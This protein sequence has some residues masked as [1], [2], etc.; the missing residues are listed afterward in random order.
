MVVKKTAMGKRLRFFFAIFSTS[1]GTMED[2]GDLYQITSFVV[3]LNVQISCGSF[4]KLLF[5]GHHVI[6][7]FTSSLMLTPMCHFWVNAFTSSSMTT[8]FNIHVLIGENFPTSSA[9]NMA[10]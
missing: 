7:L 1:V 4:G 10:K 5:L 8:K 9:P 6:Y 3:P 2:E